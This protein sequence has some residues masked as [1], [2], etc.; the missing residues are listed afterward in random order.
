MTARAS[1]W[2]RTRLCTAPARVS[3]EVR[4][5][6]MPPRGLSLS[7]CS[8]QL[9]LRKSAFPPFLGPA[10]GE[11][12]LVG[13]CQLCSRGQRS[14]R[15]MGRWNHAEG[16][17]ST[18]GTWLGPSWAPS[19]LMVIPRGCLTLS[20]P[21]WN[22]IR[23]QRTTSNVWK[24]THVPE[25]WAGPGLLWLNFLWLWAMCLQYAGS[26]PL[27]AGNKIYKFFRI[28]FIS[29]DLLIRCVISES[30]AE[31]TLGLQLGGG[32]PIQPQLDLCLPW[33]EHPLR[34]WGPKLKLQVLQKLCLTAWSG[35]KSPLDTS[36]LCSQT[37][38]A[39]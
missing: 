7:L 22:S 29:L 3:C 15:W 1:R 30:A 38:R 8:L 24:S 17:R 28:Q 11:E 39:L 10:G 4:S 19:H 2:G 9:F 13:S 36:Q 26:E 35:D 33:L 12:H 32:S 21:S 31:L 6:W 18:S 25:G 34:S 5:F 27:R 20:F 23:L 16:C 37:L 14:S